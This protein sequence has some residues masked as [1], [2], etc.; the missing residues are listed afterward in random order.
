MSPNSELLTPNSTLWWR[1]KKRR[2]VWRVPSAWKEAGR[3]PVQQARILL[4]QVDV[5]VKEVSE[6]KRG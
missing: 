2:R 1:E 5:C 6:W 3:I 4:L